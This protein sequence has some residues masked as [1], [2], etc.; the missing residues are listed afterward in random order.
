MIFQQVYGFGKV[1]ATILGAPGETVTY[2]GIESGSVVLDEHG[3]ATVRLMSGDYSLTGSVSS[4]TANRRLRPNSPVLG[5]YPD[6]YIYWYGRIR[7]GHELKT[8]YG[9]ASYTNRYVTQNTN[10]ITVYAQARGYSGSGYNTYA[11]AYFDDIDLTGYTGFKFTV[12]DL[13]DQNGGN[14][15]RTCGQETNDTYKFNT[16]FS[17]AGTH[18]VT[19]DPSITRKPIGVRQYT[20]SSSTTSWKTHSFAL[21]AL[22]LE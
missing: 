22:W 6:G 11:A 1:N 10:D 5:V 7:D 17:T 14:N 16:E 21:K 2:T 3:E 4:Y 9:Q 8:A 15:E 20:G 13:Y 19:I 18:A 12:G